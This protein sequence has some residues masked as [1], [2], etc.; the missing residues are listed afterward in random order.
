MRP[1]NCDW[2]T[3][4]CQGPLGC[5]AVTENLRLRADLSTTAAQLQFEQDDNARL[6]VDLDL[7]TREATRLLES[8]VNEHCSPVPKWKALPD[9]VGVL[10]QLSNA[11]TIVRD[12][13]AALYEATTNGRWTK[14]EQC[15]E[16]AI[17]KEVYDSLRDPARRALEGSQ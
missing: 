10:S 4:E 9:L 5:K 12:Y 6:R 2:E 13:K 15:G 8:F 1:C 7:A 17:S 11:V 3:G 14:G 16:W